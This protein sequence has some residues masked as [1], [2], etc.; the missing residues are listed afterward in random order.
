MKCT[1]SLLATLVVCCAFLALAG[2]PVFAQPS[3]TGRPSS[4]V[5]AITAPPSLPALPSDTEGPSGIT[6]P[7]TITARPSSVTS[8]VVVPTPIN[9]TIVGNAT[10][11]VTGTAIV[12]PTPIPINPRP[13]SPT[14]RSTATVSPLP[15]FN[16]NAAGRLA[17]NMVGVTWIIT[18]AVGAFVYRIAEF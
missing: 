13:A 7:A 2:T 12:Q 3:V 18:L 8:G 16:V 17:E 6:V 1:R 5:P 11:P 4:G 10:R 9:G 15:P 14:A